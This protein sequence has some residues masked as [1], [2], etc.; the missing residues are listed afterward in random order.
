MWSR[1]RARSGSCGWRSPPRRGPAPSWRPCAARWCGAA[2]SRSARSTCRSTGRTGSPSPAPT[3][4]ASRRCSARCSAGSRW[5][6]ATASLGSGV[7]VGEVDQARGLF[8]GDRAAAGRVLRGGPRTGPRRGAHAARQVRPEGRPRAAPGGDAVPGRAHPGR[9]G[10]AAGAGASTCWSWTSRPTTSTC[11]RSNSW[12]RRST[13]LHGHAA[14]GHPRPA[15]AGGGAHHPPGRGGRTGRSP[16]AEFVGDADGVHPGPGVADVVGQ[17]HAGRAAR[18]CGRGC[19]RSS[20]ASPVKPSSVTSASARALLGD[21]LDHQLR[22]PGTHGLHQRVPG[23]L[24]AEPG[25][26]RRPGRRP[27]AP[28]RRGRTSRAAAARPRSRSPRRR[29]PPRSSGRGTPGPTP[30]SARSRGR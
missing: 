1:S 22:Q 26:R 6:R 14:A 21:D 20:S 24:A 16:R 11:P 30:T 25:A 8:L 5:T 10:A 17:H 3:A 28:R 9:A 18:R 4:R 27:A 19:G 29:R 2:T 23:Q 15:D 12:S 7:V 13:R